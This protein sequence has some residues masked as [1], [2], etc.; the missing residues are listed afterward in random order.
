MIKIA[1][2]FQQVPKNGKQ[3]DIENVSQLNIAA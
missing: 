3:H 2:H 1:R